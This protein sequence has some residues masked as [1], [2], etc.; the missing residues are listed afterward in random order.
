MLTSLKIKKLFGVWNYNLNLAKDISIISGPNGYGKTTILRIIRDVFEDD[1]LDLT[2]IP[3][4]EI[5]LE[6]DKGTIVTFKKDNGLFYCNEQVINVPYDIS[7]YVD[8]KRLF[9][10]NNQSNGN[11]MN[12]FSIS[13]DNNETL[14]VKKG[15]LGASFQDVLIVSDVKIKGG[16]EHAPYVL[17][18]LSLYLN[19]GNALFLDSNR[20]YNPDF[21]KANNRYPIRQKEGEMQYHVIDDISNTLKKEISVA[22]DNYARF[23]SKLDSILLLQLSTQL[24]EESK[25]NNEYTKNDYLKNI[26]EI[27]AKIDKLSKYG[28]LNERENAKAPRNVYN[29]SYSLIY[30]IYANNY[31][32]KLGEF[33][34]IVAK[35]DLFSNIINNK[36]LNKKMVLDLKNGIRVI[37]N[38]NNE[39]A[40]KNLSSGEKEIIVLYFKLLF[41]DDSS[42][43][44]CLFLIDEPEI[45]LHVEWQYQIMDDLK[46][47][48]E[49]R[50]KYLNVQ[51]QM[52]ICTHSPQIIGNHWDSVIE[53]ANIG[54][55][56]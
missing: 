48:F 30:K 33:D 1:L 29:S 44:Y 7:R 12:A 2:S 50:T 25:N 21:Y 10:K 55:A 11:E 5:Y 20:L 52:I 24:A 27:D 18:L 39:I 3:F 19:C 51:K 47:I 35:L 41:E 32:R 40:L 56:S 46:T 43:D 53:L 23:S 14:L 8:K 45:S 13:L 31:K 34:E 28:L 6:D 37:D 16:V 54:E 26:E 38:N 22:I 15:E 4:D 42:K 17:D 36:L 49:T 9:Y